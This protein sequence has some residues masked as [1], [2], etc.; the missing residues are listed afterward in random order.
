MGGRAPDE[1]DMI[2]ID[3][4]WSL[5][6]QALTR[7]RAHAAF[8]SVGVRLLRPWFAAL[9]PPLRFGSARLGR[10]LGVNAVGKLKREEGEERRRVG[11][12]VTW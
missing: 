2:S 11:I 1:R 8:L 3:V 7:A 9:R 4:S 10:Y 6:L 12:A 5:G